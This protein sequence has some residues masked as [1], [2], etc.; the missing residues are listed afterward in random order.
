MGSS[1]PFHQHLHSAGYLTQAFDMF[2]ILAL[3]LLSTA[4]TAF[5]AQAYQQC[6]GINWTGS[7]TCDQGWTC[8]VENPYF[9]QC[10]EST[11]SSVL[12]SASSILSS[13][14]SVLSSASSTTS[15][16]TAAVFT[17]LTYK[18]SFTHYG[19]GDAWGSPNCNTDTAACGF[20]TNPGF[21]AAV[22]QNLYGSASGHGPACG[23]CW[24]LTGETDS[25][26]NPLPNAGTSIV[27]MINNLCP[28]VANPPN[29]LCTPA[30]TSDTNSLGA[31]VNFDLCSDS[32]AQT[33]FFGNSGNGLA[34]GSATQVD[35]TEYIGTVH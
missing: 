32:G 29:P 10:L 24:R 33:A 18:A 26:G 31:N 30:T 8:Q 14:S 17:G 11:N 23:E 15:S 6:G 22:S 1:F 4:V 34:I 3:T 5:A 19:S 35:C 7:T 27:V 28:A 13:A 25:S 20:Y 9:S 21:S 12:S 16:T 2:Q